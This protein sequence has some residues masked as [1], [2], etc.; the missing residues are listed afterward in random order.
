MDL[1]HGGLWEG[2]LREDIAQNPIDLMDAL[3]SDDE[4]APVAPPPL[5]ERVGEGLEKRSG[6]VV[7]QDAIKN[8]S[9]GRVGGVV[10][11]AAASGEAADGAGVGVK[12]RFMVSPEVKKAKKRR[13]NA[14]TERRAEIGVKRLHA[15]LRNAGVEEED[16][17]ISWGL[18]SSDLCSCICDWTHRMRGVGDRDLSP[19]AI[20]WRSNGLL[21]C[22]FKVADS[23]LGE[24]PPH[25]VACLN[26]LG[27]KMRKLQE[28][29]AAPG[30]RACMARCDCE[31][32][33][34]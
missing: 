28:D 10:G 18:E 33:C 4:F 9:G 11:S 31:L 20:T 30:Q 26:A 15:C 6:V 25:K 5:N 27:N 21:R 2:H 3:T 8:N 22:L 13:V 14:N 19:R 24:A 7:G 32:P 29:G 34:A 23:S 1:R 12:R 16:V 17:V